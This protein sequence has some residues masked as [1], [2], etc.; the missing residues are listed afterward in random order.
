MPD[1]TPGSVV[2]KLGVFVKVPQPEWEAF[3]VRRQEWEKPFEG[4]V[5]YKILGGLG[6]ELL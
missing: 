2:V 1:N 4:C 6:R 3:A 5:Q